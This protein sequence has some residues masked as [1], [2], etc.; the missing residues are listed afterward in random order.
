MQV[1]AR[2]EETTL[3]ELPSLSTEWLLQTYKSSSAG[4]VSS[5]TPCSHLIVLDRCIKALPWPQELGQLS[6]SLIC[7]ETEV[8]R[9]K[10]SGPTSKREVVTE[11]IQDFLGP[12]FAT[13]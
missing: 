11:Q 6:L 2:K 3:T 7:R 13:K 9:E 8:Q 1:L 4:P 12:T 5:C 10:L